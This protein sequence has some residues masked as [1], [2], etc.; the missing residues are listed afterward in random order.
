[1]SVQLMASVSIQF[2]KMSGA[3]NDFVLIDNMGDQL[4]FDAPALARSLCDRH[5]GIGADGMILL[6]PSARSDFQMQYYNADGSFGGMCGN[7][8]RCAAVLAQKLGYTSEAFNFEAVRHVYRGHINGSIV[9]MLMRQPRDIRA[10]VFI[11]EWEHL[12]GRGCFVDTGA[13]HAVFFVEDVAGIDVPSIGRVIRE[14]AAFAPSGANVNFVQVLAADRIRMRTYE[15]GVE[16]ETLA[17]GTGA[18]ASALMA[19]RIKK[20]KPPIAVET[21]SGRRLGVDFRVSN[22]TYTDITL[23][24]EASIVFS[25]KVL[26][27]DNSSEIVAY[28]DAE[29]IG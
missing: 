28:P 12:L 10:Q 17:C 18:I 14:D 7:G 22:L 25:G 16:A 29:R 27:D 19:C 8:G 6:V 1:M 4:Q 23:E 21:R 26:V 9:Q 15:R 24:G 20:V 13:P 11:P 3:G 2:V 5:F